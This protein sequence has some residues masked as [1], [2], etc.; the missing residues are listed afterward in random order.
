MSSFSI[1]AQ[2]VRTFLAA[3]VIAAALFLAQTHDALTD[4]T[5]PL[6][7]G[8]LHVLGV[9]AH[10]SGAMMSIGRLEVPWTRD[11]AGGNL[12]LVL[13]AIT[14]WV[15]RNERSFTRL[16]LRAA[17]AVPAALAAN[18]ARV[19]TLIVYRTAFYPTVE[20]PQSH[21]FM[22]LIWLV[23][24]VTCI[25]PKSERALSFSWMETLHAAAV[26]A[27]LA[28]LAG[29]PNS[30]WMIV[31]AVMA[32]SRCQVRRDHSRLRISLTLLWII[33][34]AA[35]AAI[36]MESFWLPWLLA[37]PP[38]LDLRWAGRISGIC[39]ILSTH[40]MI[41]MQKWSIL[42]AG[43]GLLLT[44]AP[45]LKRPPS[46]GG[47]PCISV[48]ATGWLRALR[49][50]SL[51]CFACPFM[52]STL[53]A[54]GFEKWTPPATVESR[55]IG[56]DGYEV[57]LADQPS[58]I[59]LICYAA[60]SRDRHHTIK[61]CLKYRGVEITN[62]SEN[63]HVYTDGSH[64]L[65]E[66][67]LQKGKLCNDYEDYLQNTFHPLTDPGIHLIFVAPREQIG[68]TDFE[69]QCQHL[70]VQFQSACTVKL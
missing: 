64:W 68:E 27:L 32:L 52:A 3:S 69:S 9:P 15:N 12:L 66:F 25:L 47:E 18:V 46:N 37:C 61:V 50:I 63:S 51:V 8:T 60:A 20:S 35:I 6:V 5:R 1:P 58:Q 21:Y 57:R 59:G 56:N 39:V 62:E 30:I 44:L 34:G 31:C 41:A 13:L 45:A 67:F 10:D 65:R 42:L 48:P 53:L 17:L 24:F 33:T 23:P 22:G 29:T 40:P 4:V 28:P 11:C 14:I 49:L 55:C 16:L 43:T 36:N 70:A 26:V 7:I 19:L 38:L 2:A 54:L